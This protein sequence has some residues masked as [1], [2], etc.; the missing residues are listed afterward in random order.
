MAGFRKLIRELFIHSSS[1]FENLTPLPRLVLYKEP[2]PLVDKPAL[3]DKALKGFQNPTGL[4]TTGC[5]SL[6]KT[7]AFA[8]TPE[9]ASPEQFAG[10]PLGLA[11]ARRAAL[12][13]G[14][15]SASGH[16]L[17]ARTARSC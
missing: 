5:Y 1:F 16:A 10:V 3:Y 8:G 9:F 12:G 7:S 13:D 17:T 11:L 2:S 14:D 15:V 6:Y 4:P